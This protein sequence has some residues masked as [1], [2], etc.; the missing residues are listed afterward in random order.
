MKTKFLLSIFVLTLG[1]QACQNSIDDMNNESLL[2]EEP[3]IDAFKGTNKSGLELNVDFIDQINSQIE[4]KGLNFR[5]LKIEYITANNSEEAGRE[6]LQRDLGNKQL[7]FDFVPFDE[8][9]A[10]SGP[11]DG[12][13]DNI[14]YAIDQTDDAVPPFGG[15]TAAQTDEIITRSFGTWEEASCSNLDLTRL[16]VV[17]YLKQGFLSG[18]IQPMM[19]QCVGSMKGDA[20][21]T[22][23]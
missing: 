12:E 3:A 7:A 4:S 19:I 9:R 22:Y 15:L 18:V 5:L 2:V 13:N 1:F 14:T 21:C 8:R 11:V 6:I 17:I 20:I 16:F 23:T 10:W